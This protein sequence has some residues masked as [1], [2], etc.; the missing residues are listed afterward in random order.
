M[1]Y[2]GHIVGNGQVKPVLA[3]VEA[4]T[5]FPAPQCKRELKR[6]VGMAGYYRKFCPNFP[7]IA[8]PLTCLLQ[9][10]CPFLWNETCQQAFEQIKAILMVSP[11][12]SSPN[13]DK[14]FVFLLSNKNKLY[15]A[16]KDIGNMIFEGLKMGLD[17]Q[18][19]LK[20]FLGEEYYKN[21]EKE[22]RLI[23]ELWG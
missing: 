7:T 13:F 6:F 19:I 23:K 10:N 4:T 12:L 2:L 3:K 21:L 11:V 20:E 5:N 9:K 1:E 15:L 18:H 16:D 17:V 8:N 14:E 22:K